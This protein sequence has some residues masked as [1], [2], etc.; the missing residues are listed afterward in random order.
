[1]LIFRIVLVCVMTLIPIAGLILHPHVFDNEVQ[2]RFGGIFTLGV[3]MLALGLVKERTFSPLIWNL[4]K[5]TT[6][7][8]VILAAVFCFYSVK[9][10][11]NTVYW[12]RSGRAVMQ[13]VQEN[14]LGEAIKR[15]PPMFVG[16]A[17]CLPYEGQWEAARRWYWES[18]KSKVKIK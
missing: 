7:I 11:V 4:R 17:W 14:P 8:L 13:W 1:M 12:D 16:S 18:Q 15:T 2:G 6:Q 5:S 10:R 9:Q 3:M